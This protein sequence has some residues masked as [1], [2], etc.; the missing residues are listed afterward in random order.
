MHGRITK[1]AELL[2]KASDMLL[3]SQ[4]TV[5]CSPALTTSTLSAAAIH[6]RPTIRQVGNA[7]SA[8][9]LVRARSMMQSSTNGG[10]FRRLNQSERLRASSGT[11]FPQGKKGKKAEQVKQKPFEFALLNCTREDSDDEEDDNLRR[12][13]IVERGIA[14][15]GEQDSESTIREKLVS[16]LK[17]K[18]GMIGLNDFQFVKLAQK[19]I[20]ILHLSKGAEYSYEIAKKLVGQGLLYIRIKKHFQFVIDEHVSEDSESDLPL[21][22]APRHLQQYCL[23]QFQPQHHHHSPLQS[24]P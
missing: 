23:H 1:A 24:V 13:M 9:T 2:R 12:E 7:A 8:E 21:Q 22:L 6:S 14:T 4:G 10:V 11:N 19:K 5:S 16:S 20:S 3:E 17:D 18:Y 15:L